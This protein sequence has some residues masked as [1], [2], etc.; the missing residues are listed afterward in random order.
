VGARW[1]DRLGA[2]RHDGAVRWATWQSG[3]TVYTVTTDGPSSLLRKAVATFPHQGPVETTTL[4][5]VH[6][7]WSRILAD[8]KG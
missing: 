7:G 6:E 5:R 8:L 3:D 4:V 1:D 2:W